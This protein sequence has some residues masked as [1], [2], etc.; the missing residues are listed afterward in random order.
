MLL[1]MQ[2]GTSTNST[3]GSYF[4]RKLIGGAEVSSCELT[5]INRGRRKH[6]GDIE[7]ESASHGL[8][9]CLDAPT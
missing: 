3:S 5:I 2:T 4:G 9:P 6:S 1:Q 7:M 8:L